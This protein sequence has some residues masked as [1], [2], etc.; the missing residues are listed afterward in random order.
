MAPTCPTSSV[1][2]GLTRSTTYV[3]HDCVIAVPHLGL[4]GFGLGG[5]GGCGGGGLGYGGVGDGAARD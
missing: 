2:T 5:Y 4:V 3:Q 1:N